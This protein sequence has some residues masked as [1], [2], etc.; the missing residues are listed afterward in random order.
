[1]AWLIGI[2]EA[3]YG[4]NLGPFVMSAVA[5]RV[6]PAHLDGDLWSALAPAVRR[7]EEEDDGRLL[8]ADS[9]VVYSTARGLHALE[10]GVLACLGLHCVNGATSLA[11]LLDHVC[12]HH[13]ELKEEC[14]YHG[15]TSVPVEV[16]ADELATVRER[17]RGACVGGAL[18]T[19]TAQSV[20][21]C[22]PR[23][24]AVLDRWESKAVVLALALAELCRRILPAD[25]DDEPACFFI[26]KHGGRNNYAA[27]LQQ[28]FTDGLVLAEEEGRE[29]SVYRVQGMTRPVRVTFEPRAD[30]AHFP[31]ALASM[32]SKYLR[33]L[34]MLEFNRFWQQ[35]VPTLK[36]TA[37][38][39][40]DAARFLAAIQPAATKLGV[41]AEALWRR[42]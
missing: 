35:H 18:T 24:N 4:P 26:D 8:I 13:T 37:G 28:V 27:M 40:S 41:A 30:G 32:V 12:P 3:G 16:D 6:P 33:E 36:P 9:K 29:R 5:C 31:V 19:L 14:W 1:M 25:A 38:Y 22:P 20:L 7:A 17:L 21:V 42:K 34:C 10:T 2:D 11:S 39:P 23:F 15:T